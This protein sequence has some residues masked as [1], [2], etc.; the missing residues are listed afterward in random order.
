MNFNMICSD[1]KS[2]TMIV[3]QSILSLAL[4]SWLT[5]MILWLIRRILEEIMSYMCPLGQRLSPKNIMGLKF[6][7]YA[8]MLLNCC[9]YVAIIWFVGKKKKILLFIC[10]LLGFFFFFFLVEGLIARKSCYELWLSISCGI[11][12]L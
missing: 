11:K 3:T 6:L 2:S 7:F 8:H 10:Q 1:R 5:F 9:N 4:L 12:I